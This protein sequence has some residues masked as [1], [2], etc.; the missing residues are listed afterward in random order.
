MLSVG[1]NSSSLTISEDWRLGKRSKFI[2]CF[3]LGGLVCW[4][5]PINFSPYTET[6]ILIDRVRLLGYA[7]C[8]GLV[9]SMTLEILGCYE[10]KLLESPIKQFG[11]FTGAGLVSGV[12]LILSVWLIEYEFVGR[13]IFIY[14]SL[15][16]GGI[17]FTVLLVLGKLA[18]VNPHKVMLLVS[19]ELAVRF[20]QAASVSKLKCD[21]FEH[22][23]MNLDSAFVRRCQQEK[24]DLMVVD[25]LSNFKEAETLSI[26]AMGIK[27]MEVKH[28]WEDWFRRLPPEFVDHSWLVHL[29]LRL[30]N[31]FPKRIKRLID[32]T[33][34]IVGLILALPIILLAALGIVFGSGFPI[35]FS[36]TR[37]GFLGEPYTLFK[38]RTMASDAEKNGARWAEENDR[39]VTKIGAFLRKWRIDELP[40]LWNV[41]KGEMSLVGPRPERPEL[42]SS[43]VKRIPHWRYR[44][45]VKPGLTGWAQIRFEYASDMESS[46]EKLAYDL[47]YVKNA[48]FFLDMEIILSTLR[49]LSKGSR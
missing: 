2:L 35:F 30:R 44:S 45:L 31:P 21:W 6:L 9:F 49:S 46:E 29:D 28:F 15:G 36:Q 12:I 26:L 25:D 41:L 4:F 14:L 1:K 34:S 16:T 39:R 19:P 13:Y 43:L 32:V 27:I 17:S 42:E 3:A 7:L 24:I 38:L 33:L 23:C 18:S 37:S 48:S 22:D 10:D 20:Q 47:Y 5:V 8:F 11:L 40:Q